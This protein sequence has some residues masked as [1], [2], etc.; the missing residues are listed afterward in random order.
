MENSDLEP[1]SAAASPSVRPSYEELVKRCDELQLD[2]ARMRS[3]S[4]AKAASTISPPPPTRTP[5]GKSSTTRPTSS[6]TPSSS[7][8]LVSK[9]AAE[10]V[11]LRRQVAMYE[12]AIV[13]SENNFAALRTEVAK[14]RNALAAQNVTVVAQTLEQDS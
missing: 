9:Q 5:L 3:L 8:T 4:T 7:S 11:K 2:I 12:A 14:L 6:Q 1:S 10:L 13:D